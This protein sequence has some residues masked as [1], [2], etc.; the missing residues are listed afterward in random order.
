M[1][2]MDRVEGQWRKKKTPPFDVGDTVDVHVRIRE[3][4]KERIQIFNGTVLSI[5]GH[6]LGTMFTVRRIVAGE[7]VER[8]FPMHSPT[9]VDVKVK[10]RG[11]TRRAKVYYLRKRVGKSTRLREKH[12]EIEATKAAKPVNGKKDAPPAS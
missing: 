2:P 12:V 5:R 8:I 6:G 7:G 11:E 3:G 10:R 1:H 4:D 9:L